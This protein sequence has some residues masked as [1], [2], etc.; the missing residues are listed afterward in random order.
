RSSELAFVQRGPRWQL[1]RDET[2]PQQVVRLFAQAGNTLPSWFD[3]DQ[4]GQLVPGTAGILA[5]LHR[6]C[7]SHHIHIVDILT[8]IT[9]Q[10][11]DSATISALGQ[12][13]NQSP[14]PE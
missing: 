10:V 14:T 7:E 8:R 13:S 2:V 4:V 11:A 9:Q 6:V 1:Q 5:C 12:V 3:R